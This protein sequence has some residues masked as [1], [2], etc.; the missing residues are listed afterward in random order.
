MAEAREAPGKSM[1]YGAQGLAETLAEEAAVAR[2]K[3]LGPENVKRVTPSNDKINDVADDL[4]SD[5]GID[6]QKQQD[7][8]REFK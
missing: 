8:D 3:I 4:D 6:R 1:A 5:E 2:T 7:K